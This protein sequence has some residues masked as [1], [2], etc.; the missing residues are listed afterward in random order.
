MVR[1]E[2]A[3]VP[4]LGPTR[5]VAEGALTDFSPGAFAGKK[6]LVSGGLSGIG[7]AVAN[8]FAALGAS[9]V[10]AGLGGR[11]EVLDGAVQAAKCDVRS[12][13]DVARLVG[14]LERLDV[15]VNCAGVIARE[16]EYDAGVFEDVLS[17]NLV[18]TLRLCM[19]AASLLQASS[20][21]I[22]NIASLY[23]V[24][25][26]PH[27]PA[28]GA[29]KAAVSQLTKSL[30]IAL[31][32]RGIRVNAVAPGWVRTGFTAPVQADPEASRRAVERTP[33]GRWA[34]PDDIS[35]PV[36]FL[37]SRDAAFVTGAVLA[38]DGGYS[39]T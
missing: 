30:A 29:S 18:G 26:S 13:E 39:A 17:V 37:C 5:Q 12:A 16:K 31:A 32:P 27:A 25:G 11:S 21:C 15:L 36:V 10:A 6:A 14:G 24:A 8:R 33:L 19:A 3:R 7:A 4:G 1:P 23:A 28:Y 38:V 20:G 9:V 35:G 22:V 34:E 2:G